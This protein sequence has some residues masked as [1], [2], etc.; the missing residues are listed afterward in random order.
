MHF[1][2]ETKTKTRTRTAKHKAHIP[3]LRIYSMSCADIPRYPHEK[4]RYRAEIN[5]ATGPRSIARARRSATTR[6]CRRG[7]EQRRKE[8][9]SNRLDHDVHEA[10]WASARMQHIL[11]EAQCDRLWSWSLVCSSVFGTSMT[12][13]RACVSACVLTSAQ[14][15]PGKMETGSLACFSAEKPERSGRR[16]VWP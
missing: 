16:W 8:E 5:A 4:C 9:I 15:G 14:W 1:S 6:C 3:C 7:F 10:G 13:L 11:R 2:V 12:A